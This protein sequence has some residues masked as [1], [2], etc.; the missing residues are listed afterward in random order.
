MD[1]NRKEMID[2]VSAHSFRD[3]DTMRLPCSWALLIAER[4][5]VD[6]SIIGSLCNEQ[7]IKIT[8]CQL[9]CF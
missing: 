1:A 3:G 6:P 8:G 5:D 4:F 2:S 9:G 7:N